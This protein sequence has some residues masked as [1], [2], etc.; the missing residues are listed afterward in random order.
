MDTESAKQEAQGRRDLDPIEWAILGILIG[1]A[2]LTLT[3]QKKIEDRRKAREAE[4]ERKATAGNLIRLDRMRQILAE[5]RV[6]ASTL[7]E[8]GQL[9]VDES[10]TGITRGSIG[11]RSEQEEE[12]FNRGFESMLH[13]I[14]RLNRLI[15]EIDLEG[16]PLSEKDK[17]DFVDRPIENIKQK[18]ATA[19]NPDT[20]PTQRVNVII[21]LL[22]TYDVLIGD[23][24]RTLE[25]SLKPS[26]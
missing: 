17:A 12:R 16:L 14:G 4:A 6:F 2:S 15:G 21:D 7:P 20:P 25:A 3:I 22:A 9:V 13:G 5:L 11:F 24:K 8:M 18:T 23:L 10:K 1:G 19:I 26:P